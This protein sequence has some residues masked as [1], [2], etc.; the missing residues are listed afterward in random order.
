MLKK[1]S[2]FRSSWS[3]RGRRAEYT[4]RLTSPISVTPFKARVTMHCEMSSMSSRYPLS[5]NLKAQTQ[6]TF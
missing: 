5:P 1:E 3:M 4:I 2:E 6:A